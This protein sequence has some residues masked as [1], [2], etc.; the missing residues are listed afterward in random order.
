MKGQRFYATNL[1]ETIRE[2]GRTKRWV[3]SR[4]GFSE[5]M[6]GHVI[7]RRKTIGFQAAE[8]IATSLAVPF[9]L[10]FES[11]DVDQSSPN[12]EQAA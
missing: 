4:A 9:F 6:L 7:A 2:Q 11:T 12:Q 3:A 8:R 5:S 10:L 1:E